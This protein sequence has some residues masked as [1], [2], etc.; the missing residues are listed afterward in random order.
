MVARKLG[1]AVVAEGVETIPVWKTLARLGC[2]T[3]QGYL[4][5][6]PEPADVVTR[7]LIHSPGAPAVEEVAV[8]PASA[9][10]VDC[11]LRLVDRR[12]GGSGVV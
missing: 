9:E 5:A 1:L 2:T 11:P 7:M 6:R 3:A 10:R 8:G 4:I 12:V